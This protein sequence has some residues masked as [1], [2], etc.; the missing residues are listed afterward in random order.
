MKYIDLYCDESRQDLLSNQKAINDTN[1]YSCI[2][3]LLVPREHREQ[4]KSKINSLKQ[5]F[6]VNGEFKWGNVSTN[7]YEFYKE[8]V[9]IFFDDSNLSLCFRCIVIDASKIDN[10]KF[11]QGSHEL[12]YYKFYYQ[13]IKNWIN[14]DS[15]YYIFTDFKTNKETNRL[16]ELKRIL[17]YDL[18][19][20]NIEIVQAIDSSE[21]VIMQM[22]NILMGTVAYKFNF[23]NSGASISKKALVSYI[24][25]KLG[26]EILPTS[27]SEVKF[28]VFKIMLGGGI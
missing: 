8:L 13:L 27:K 21:S 2:G 3:G 7:K 18:S 26:H 28:N 19:N 6:S 16:H 23:G 17:N 11:N 20:N 24:E 14:E 4:L 22:Q 15:M 12:G 10:E 1:K 9:N 25:E 5:D